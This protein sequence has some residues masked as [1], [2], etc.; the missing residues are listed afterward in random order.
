M[1]VQES[2]VRG[3]TSRHIVQLFDSDESRVEAVAAF[4]AEGHRHGDALI[5]VARPSNWTA[6]VE[7]LE[8][9]D[10]PVKALVSSGTLVARDAHETLSR[11]S[12]RDSLDA[13]AFQSV[14]AKAVLA[15]GRRG[16]IRAYG[17]MVDILAQRIDLAD[18]LT[19]ENLWNDL[20]ARTPLDL[21]CGYSAAHFVTGNTHRALREICRAHTHVHSVP[22]DPMAGWILTSAHNQPD[23]ESAILN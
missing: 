3:A 5:A 1:T 21:M 22:H 4:L 20:A 18:A 14:V 16:R 23:G 10:V 17:E 2:V 11:L 6:I 15:L 13:G 19:L 8:A 9:M 7:R 12:R